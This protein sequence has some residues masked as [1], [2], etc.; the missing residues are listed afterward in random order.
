MGDY[1]GLDRI[2]SIILLI[3]PF[4]AW[5]CG[6]ITKI[7]DGHYVAAIIRIFF[8]CWIIWAADIVLTILNGCNVNVWRLIKV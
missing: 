7:K 4:T 5:V 6:F 8:G 2:I 3:I 1:F